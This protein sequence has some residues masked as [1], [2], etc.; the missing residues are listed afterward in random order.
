MLIVPNQGS[1]PNL[2]EDAV[3]EI[4]CYVNSKGVEPIALKRQDT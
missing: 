1:I 4:P 3:V 2:R